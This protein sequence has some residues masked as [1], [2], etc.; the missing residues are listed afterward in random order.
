MTMIDFHHR[1]SH[2][3]TESGM[4]DSPEMP[5]SIRSPSMSTLGGTPDR[6]SPPHSRSPFNADK[7]SSKTSE[8]KSYPSAASIPIILAGLNGMK[9]LRGERRD[10]ETRHEKE[11]SEDTLATIDSLNEDQNVQHNEKVE[12]RGSIGLGLGILQEPFQLIEERSISRSSAGNTSKH[13]R[14]QNN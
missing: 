7:S 10:T 5:M 9:A 3:R 2:R 13:S 12:Q 1:H 11:R 14:M 8:M 4:I 6:S